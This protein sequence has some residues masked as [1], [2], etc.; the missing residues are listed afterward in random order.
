[1]VGNKKG[2]TSL[3]NKTKEGPAKAI[4][5]LGLFVGI[6]VAFFVFFIVAEISVLAYF[7]L[8]IAVIIIYIVYTEN[9]SLIH[10]FTDGF[11]IGVL[12]ILIA[13]FTRGVLFRFK[14]KHRKIYTSLITIPVVMIMIFVISFLLYGNTLFTLNTPMVLYSNNYIYKSFNLDYYGSLNCTFT[15][16]VP[17]AVYIMTPSEYMQWSDGYP[18]GFFYTLNDTYYADVNVPL[19]AGRWYIIINNPSQYDANIAF[20]ACSYS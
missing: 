11:L 16:T 9:H 4:G 14:P 13:L 15:S 19:T 6:V 17:L 20:S 10:T 5:V 18:N 8:V 3:K 1:M 2:K 12:G 7:V